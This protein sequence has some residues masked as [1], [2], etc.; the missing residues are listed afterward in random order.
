LLRFGHRIRRLFPWVLFFWSKT[1]SARSIILLD[2]IRLSISLQFRAGHRA[3]NGEK[4]PLSQN[5]QLDT[6]LTESLRGIASCFAFAEPGCPEWWPER[7]RSINQTGL[8]IM[9][10]RRHVRMG[11]RLPSL[12]TYPRS[13]PTIQ[14]ATKDKY[15]TIPSTG[16]NSVGLAWRRESAL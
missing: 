9:S 16:G 8:N 14:I 7:W 4:H 2:S 5:L 15:H 3:C 12:P 1:W 6:I 13:Q 10:K 11:H